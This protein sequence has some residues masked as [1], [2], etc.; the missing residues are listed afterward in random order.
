MPECFPNIR[1]F[2]DIQSFF[3]SNYED[4]HYQIAYYQ[5]EGKELADSQSSELVN[6]LVSP[7]P[8]NKTLEKGCD[9]VIVGNQLNLSF[10]FN[11]PW[12]C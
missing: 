8:L 7:N 4:V 5:T 3:I 11:L 10:I 1:S 2:H 9:L 6:L 12:M